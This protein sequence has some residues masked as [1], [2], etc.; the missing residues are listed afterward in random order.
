[1]ST[2]TSVKEILGF[3][4]TT[5]GQAKR[6]GEWMLATSRFENQTVTFTTDIQGLTLMLLM[7]I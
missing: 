3:G 7:V 2:K 5:K 1:M 4:I 6:V